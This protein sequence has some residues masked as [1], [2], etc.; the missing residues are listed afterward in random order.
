VPS[1][2]RQP[3]PGQSDGECVPHVS[4]PL[5]LL[6]SAWLAAGC[7]C[8][9]HPRGA[10][11]RPC[12]HRPGSAPGGCPHPGPAPQHRRDQGQR[13]GCEWGK[14]FPGLAATKPGPKLGM[15]SRHLQPF[16]GPWVRRVSPMGG[17]G[18]MPAPGHSTS[19]PRSPAWG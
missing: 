13:W 9:P 16:P 11:Q 2:R 10:L 1:A 15:G 14:A 3:W 19:L 7:G 17:D 12:Q 4:N 5:W 18:A 8:I 6:S